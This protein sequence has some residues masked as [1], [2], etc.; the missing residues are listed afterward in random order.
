MSE[1][2]MLLDMDADLENRV[3]ALA[4]A[5]QRESRWLI[6]DA[7]REYV[8]R[9]ERRNAHW[10]EAMQSWHNYQKDGLHITQEEMECWFDQIEAGQTASQPCACHK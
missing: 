9:E 2:A 1:T 10:D 7:V 6:Q 5:Q 4:S 3:L 8:E